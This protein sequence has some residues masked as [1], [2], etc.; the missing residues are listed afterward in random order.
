MIKYNY[1]K[2]NALTGG[3]REGNC[4]PLNIKQDNV[5]LYQHKV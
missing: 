4:P 1:L 3:L 2:K 5:L